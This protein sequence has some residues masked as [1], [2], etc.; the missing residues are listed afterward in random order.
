MRIVTVVLFLAAIG[1][2]FMAGYGLRPSAPS[3]SPYDPEYWPGSEAQ[4][5]DAYRRW[6]VKAGAPVDQV[7]GMWF[8]QL[9]FLPTRN[10][11][12]G[13]SCVKLRIERGAIGDSPVYCYDNDTMKLLAEY[14]DVE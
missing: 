13:L 14:S 2:A 5:D 4:I 1:L 11:G 12:I 7:K 9:M 10:Q 3:T 6:S 8:P